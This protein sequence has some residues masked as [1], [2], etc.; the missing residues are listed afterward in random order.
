MACDGRA[1]VATSSHPHREPHG[2]GLHRINQRK[3]GDAPRQLVPQRH[4]VQVRTNGPGVE[5]RLAV[6]L[7]QA[8]RPHTSGRLGRTPARPRPPQTHRTTQSQPSL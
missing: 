5:P 4:T 2:F 8:R 1:L 7:N 3:P 6:V